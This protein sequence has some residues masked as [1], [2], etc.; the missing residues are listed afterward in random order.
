M[1]QIKRLKCS[2]GE[3]EILKDISLNFP[4]T[5]FIGICGNSGCGKTT[6][7]NCLAGLIPYQGNIEIDGEKIHLLEED[8]MAKY[9]LKNIGFV[10]QDFK[11]FESENVAQNILF[12]LDV[13]SGS[14][15][16]RK[17]RKCEDLISVVGLEKHLKKDINK[18][19]GGEKQRVAIARALV[20]DPKIILADEPTGA[21]DSQN[22]QEIMK[23]LSKIS[24]NSLVF[25]V[26]HDYELLNQYADQIVM[27]S[28]G[29][30]EKILYNEAQEKEKYLPVCKNKVSPKRASITPSFLL[31]HTKTMLQRRKWRSLICNLITSLGLVG[32]GLS[33]SLS[34]LISSNVN[35]AYTSIVDESKIM[36]S[37][38]NVDDAS[39]TYNSLTKDEALVLYENQK[40]DCSGIGVYYVANFEEYFCDLN[41]FVISVGAYN[42]II[43]GISAR[44]INEFEWL[45]QIND[46]V[47]PTQI[48]ELNNDE[49]VLG[50]SGPMI[51]EI[52][53]GCRIEKSLTSLN[54]YL[55]THS[56]TGYFDLAHYD[57]QYWDQQLVSIK[58][59]ILTTNPGIYHT[60]HFWNEYMLENQMRFPSNEDL[61]EIDYYPWTMKK[62]YYAKTTNNELFLSSVLQDSDYDSVIFELATP[63]LYPFLYKNVPIERRNRFLLFKRYYDTLSISFEHNILDV[64]DHISNPIF[65]SYGGYSIYPSFYMMGFSGQTYFSFSD[66]LISNIE[67][68][69]LFS[70]LQS[71]E[72]YSL[73]DG[74]LCGH[75]SKSMEN[76]VIF[77]GFAGNLISGRAPDNI[78]EI[79]ISSKMLNKLTGSNELPKKPL[80]VSFTKSQTMYE[81]GSVHRDFAD[82]SLQV[83]GV[84]DSSRLSL[85]HNPFWT[86]VF[87]ELKLGI[88][89]FDLEV[90]TISFD[91]DNVK[92][93]DP[94]IKELKRAFPMLETTY[95][96]NSAKEG[97]SKI[98]NAIE[99]AVLSLSS[100][101]IIISI[102]LLSI[103]NYLHAL[104]CQKDIGLT[105]CLGVSKKESN[106][107]VYSHS[108]LMSFIS[109]SCASIELILISL[110]SSYLI[111]GNLG[112]RLTFNI[113][114]L[115]FII[116][117]GLSLG[118]SLI[119]SAF[120]VRKI[121]RKSALECLKA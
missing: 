9:R 40:S 104:E 17:K 68:D 50:V 61:N 108:I 107:F 90:N 39:K 36:I 103:C 25:V 79:A 48:N 93:I 74:V 77:Q 34:S 8:E 65:G 59:V 37:N 110:L 106:K 18:L 113:S 10:F 22:S 82:T 24:R 120:I 31:R 72:N 5:G 51:N 66:S 60:N 11:L 67:D 88:S 99:I 95:P 100:L 73:P 58:G 16:E 38:K 42:T 43:H 69:L 121:K 35:S 86:V 57:W 116:M 23:L 117:I 13:L 47:Y 7:L 45:D 29:K 91:V 114:P 30:I 6:F 53:Y 44:H 87:F 12:P 27:M 112:N 49:I 76:G 19:S 52:C 83:V 4:H 75:Y 41:D 92:N 63:E 26:S 14:S 28:D 118:I 2:F 89:A 115:S 102:L 97:I 64:S 101:T 1:I 119:S 94:T 3:T 96:L 80:Y 109:F 33:F 55:Q 81:D 71:N 56:I 98:C 84:V 111:S 78:N 46:V 21:L 85:F 105:R 54:N 32:V 62:I 20:N 70:S 15:Y